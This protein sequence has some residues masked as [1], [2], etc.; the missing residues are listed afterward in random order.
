MIQKSNSLRRGILACCAILPHLTLP[1]KI[2]GD[3]VIYRT[4]IA[5]K[6]PKIPLPERLVR[7]WWCT[8]LVGSLLFLP[9]VWVTGGCFLAR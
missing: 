1:A 4:G 3:Y 5:G 6:L 8:R 7:V 2:L 9:A